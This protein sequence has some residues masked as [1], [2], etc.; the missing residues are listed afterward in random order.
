MSILTIIQ[1][2]V[3]KQTTLPAANL[4]ASAKV[5]VVAGQSFSVRYAFRVG[6]HCFVELRQTLG[7]LGKIGY[8]YLPHVQVPL[9]EFRGVWLTTID[10]DV[11]YSQSQIQNGLQSLKDLGFNTIYP[12]VW[13]RGF[14]LYPSSIAQSFIGTA[15][16]PD[17]NFAN[18][19]MLAEVVDAARRL[20]LRVIP[21][22]EYGLMAPPNSVLATRHPA[23]LTSDLNGNQIVNGTVWLNPCHPEVQQ[24]IADLIA[25]VAERYEIEGVQLDDN[26]GIPVELGYDSFTQ[27]LYQQENQ[28][29]LMPQNPQDPQRLRWLAN[30]VTAVFKRIFTTVKM[31]RGCIISLSPNPLGF[32][33]RNRCVDWQLWHR[34]G[35]V[36]ELVLQVYRSGLVEFTA[37]LNKAE[38]IE[39]RSHIPTAIGILTGLKV[40]PVDLSLIQQQVQ[41]TRQQQFAGVSCFFYETVFYQQLVPQKVARHLADLQALF[42][43]S[44]D[45][46]F[47]DIGTHW[48]KACI[49]ALADRSLIGGYPDGSFR[50]D[51]P[52]TRAELATLMYRAFPTLPL[53]RPAVSFPDVPSS[54]WAYSMIQWSY[55]RGLFSGY[56]DGTFRPNELITNLQALIVVVSA[57]RLSPPP[58]PDT[59]LRLYFTDATQIPTWAKSSIAAAIVADRVVNYPTVRQFRPND[60]SSRGQISAL[61]CRSLQI[62][63]T[64]PLQYATWYWGLYD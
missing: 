2:T 11:L 32:S 26:F 41:T 47:S 40:K 64:V 50:P 56:P 3:F 19:D 18:R 62:A 24:F 7:S 53:V 59:L 4:P 29:K 42:P 15:I 13:Q 8:F 51:A 12:I 17:A 14:T 44:I 28:G 27:T 6:N 35:L 63:N 61:L 57:L 20:D 60:T 1:N 25:D 55:E 33:Q 58:T 22:F 54:F 45:L 36:E 5:D 43:P 31:R 48:A 21:W 16:T 34:V 39:V 30:H 9:Q 46:P 37:E 52:M 23:L 38:V 49:V 10:S